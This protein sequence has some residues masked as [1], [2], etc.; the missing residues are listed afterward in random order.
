MA[1]PTT[2]A[3]IDR[4]I[5]GCQ[6]IESEMTAREQDV[7]TLQEFIAELF[8]LEPTPVEPP[9]P[10]PPGEMVIDEPTFWT[11]V[12]R[13]GVLR[14]RSE[15]SLVDAHIIIEPGG[16]IIIDGGTLVTDGE[17]K[18]PWITHV[19]EPTMGW[20][21]GDV[22]AIG[23]YDQRWFDKNYFRP[24]TQERLVTGVNPLT[25]DAPVDFTPAYYTNLNRSV[26]I[27]SAE[28][29]DPGSTRAINGG[30]YLLRNTAFKNVGRTTSDQLSEENET[31]HYAIHFHHL[32]DTMSSI[33]GCVIVNPRRWGIGVHATRN[34]SMTNN[35]VYGAQGAGV[36]F[37][38]GSEAYNRLD[39]LLVLKSGPTHGRVR[40]NKAGGVEK[41]DGGRRPDDFDV[42]FRG[43]GVWSRGMAN[44]LTNIHCC[45]CNHTGI[46][47][48]A[49]YMDRE[50][51]VDHVGKRENLTLISCGVPLWNTWP[52]GVL[53]GDAEGLRQHL[54]NMK[55]MT[56][57]NV[58]AINFN[59]VAME[60]YH[61][62]N[63]TVDNGWFECFGYAGNTGDNAPGPWAKL[64]KG[65]KPNDT[66]QM[67][68]FIFKDVTLRGL[69]VGIHLPIACIG[70]QWFR[71]IGGEISCYVNI[72][73]SPPVVS[74]AAEFNSVALNHDHA[75]ERPPKWNDLHPPAPVDFWYADAF[76][77]TSDAQFAEGKVSHVVIDDR[78]YHHAGQAE[79]NA[80]PKLFNAVWRPL[81]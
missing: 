74:R 18:T 46:N 25:F 78:E 9:P 24:L 50:W 23:P 13:V 32:G 58:R 66:Y 16:D 42:A 10:P 52:Q 15:L 39:S 64:R 34:A 12:H 11:G 48:N 2:Q 75:P 30:M 27:E 80:D 60:F 56:Y 57:K 51:L 21:V 81:P 3:D 19:D 6:Q 73:A 20:Q 8:L 54:L 22:I 62:A 41:I 59:E 5:A 53:A 71:M 38:N 68:G 7:S 65:L 67:G 47:D 72:A 55:R 43:D 36:V 40:R 35:V 49:Y 28:P 33:D 45:E 61:T 69:Q 14:I 76:D 4:W 1:E 77:D 44:D 31:G 29:S 26:T 17:W 63:I 37:E 70:P 79:G